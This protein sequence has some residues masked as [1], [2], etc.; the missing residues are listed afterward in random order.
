MG[1]GGCGADSH[2]PQWG[3]EDASCALLT[4]ICPAGGAVSSLLGDL[5]AWEVRGGEAGLL[6]M[7]QSL[8][9]NK[10]FKQY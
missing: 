6:L 3:G 9:N 4:G 1:K 2:I 7:T 5:H 8:Q 10:I